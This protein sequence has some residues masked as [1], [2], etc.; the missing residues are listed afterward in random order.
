MTTL[1][2]KDLASL[3]YKSAYS[4]ATDVPVHFYLQSS[5][6]RMWFIYP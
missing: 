5:I 3:V 1:A 2:F 6:V 4:L